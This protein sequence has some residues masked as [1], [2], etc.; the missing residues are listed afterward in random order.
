LGEVAVAVGQALGRVAMVTAMVMAMVTA[1][2]QGPSH[3]VLAQPRPQG[4]S[5]HTAL[6]VR[7]GVGEK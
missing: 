2:K 6:A 4:M 3:P 7:I 5:C 1:T